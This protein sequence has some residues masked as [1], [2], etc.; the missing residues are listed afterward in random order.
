MLLLEQR[1]NE[2]RE[3]MY[4]KVEASEIG[5]AYVA[6]ANAKGMDGP[7]RLMEALFISMFAGTHAVVYFLRVGT[8]E[9]HVAAYICNCV[10][11]G[12]TGSMTHL[13]VDHMMT[14]PNKFAALFRKDKESYMLEGARLFPPVSV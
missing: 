3:Y 11:Y 9:Q 13:I 7:V 1:I 12:G 8:Y 10:G 5:Q 6:K 4:K 14:D 2:I